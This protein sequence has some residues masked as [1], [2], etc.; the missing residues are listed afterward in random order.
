MSV[1][2]EARTRRGLVT[3]YYSWRSKEELFDG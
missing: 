1:G 3:T 2:A